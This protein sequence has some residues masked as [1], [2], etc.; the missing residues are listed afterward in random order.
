MGKNS[1]TITCIRPNAIKKLAWKTPGSNKGGMQKF[2]FTST[3]KSQVEG[4]MQ[5]LC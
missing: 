4:D 5:G 3:E 2:Y 1:I